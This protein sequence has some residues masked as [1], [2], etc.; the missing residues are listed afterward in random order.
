L[1]WDSAFSTAPG[2]CRSAATLALVVQAICIFTASAVEKLPSPAWRDGSALEIFLNTGFYPTD[3]GIAFRDGLPWALRPL[4][5]ST[6][7]I[8]L[9][10]PLLFL[11]PWWR[12]R[13]MAALLLTYMLSAFAL[14]M[15]VGFV[16]IA[17]FTALLPLLPPQML[18]WRPE[19]PVLR[20]G[21]A[22]NSVV[23]LALVVV[24]ST[25]FVPA[26]RAGAPFVFYA[27][28]VG[29]GWT[30]FYTPEGVAS[31]DF[32]L[33]VGEDAEGRRVD[34]LTGA[35]PEHDREPPPIA[36]FLTFRERK[37]LHTAIPS[38]WHHAHPAFVTWLCR[39][40]P[41]VAAIHVEW[42]KVVAGGTIR[43]LELFGGPCERPP[44]ARRN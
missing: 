33:V 36:R 30:M 39:K 8:E 16:P 32:V 15:D 38:R 22:A 41:E 27:L 31:R 23:A 25:S 43:W 20:S 26:V 21:R 3:I 42:G 37:A 1:S 12:V 35:P 19:G 9:V 13:A 34:L 11:L 6:L 29:Q 24:V 44:T 10:A 28:G 7:V 2:G 17:G 18:R 5:L 4:T 40:Y 14:C